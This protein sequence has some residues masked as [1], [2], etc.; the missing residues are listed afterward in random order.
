[1]RLPFTLLPELVAGGF[2][3]RVLVP[4][5]VLTLL[6]KKILKRSAKRIHGILVVPRTLEWVVESFKLAI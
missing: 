3:M 4:V 1:M 2:V 6:R 5:K